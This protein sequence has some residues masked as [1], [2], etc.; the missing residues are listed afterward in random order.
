[1]RLGIRGKFFLAS[2][3]LIVGV[4]LATALYLERELRRWQ[5]ETT[6]ERLREHTIAARE[7][8]ERLPWPLQSATVDSAIKA[9]GHSL[10]SRITVID[11]EGRVL[12]DS[13]VPPIRCQG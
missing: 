6:T 11:A 4:G 7:L 5:D 1:M 10:V 8:L 12:G 9:L 13:E 3:T 2:L